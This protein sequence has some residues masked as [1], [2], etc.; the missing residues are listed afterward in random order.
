MDDPTIN[1]K[2]AFNKRIFDESRSVAYSLLARETR[3][4]I[5]D[6]SRTTITASDPN[7]LKQRPTTFVKRMKTMHGSPTF[8]SLLDWIRRAY[9]H[10]LRPVQTT[11]SNATQVIAS[12]DTLTVNLPTFLADSV[13]RFLRFRK[14]RVRASTEDP[15]VGQRLSESP[16][17]RF[18]TS[19]GRLR[20]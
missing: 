8:S 16:C 7:H 14:T 10:T 18:F 20:S 5:S 4:E 6:C 19:S 3:S 2:N 15:S 11:S 1:K 17:P 12:D 13:S 9:F